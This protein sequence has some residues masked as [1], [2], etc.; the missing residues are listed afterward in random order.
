MVWTSY[1]MGFIGTGR[2]RL[3]LSSSRRSLRFAGQ[4]ERL[5]LRMFVY[6]VATASQAVEPK[7]SEAF[8]ITTWLRRV[9]AFIICRSPFSVSRF[10]F[11]SFLQ[12][13]SYAAT[14]LPP[15]YPL[16]VFLRKY[17]E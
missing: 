8:R 13:A 7:R 12:V 4:P 16:P 1:H 2:E 9:S 15:T 11:S 3:Q 14:L 17:E 5:S 10:A 6:H